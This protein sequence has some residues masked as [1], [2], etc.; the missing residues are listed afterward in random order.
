M[1]LNIRSEAAIGVGRSY[2]VQPKSS[3]AE[4]DGATPSDPREEKKNIY[5]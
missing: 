1:S 2:T 5:S 4:L 3:A